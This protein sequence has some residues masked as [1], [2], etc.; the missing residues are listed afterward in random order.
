M[1]ICLLVLTSLV[2]LAG[3]AFAKTKTL[4][5]G[6]AN[7]TNL[8][9]VEV[10]YSN[11]R[12]EVTG[13]ILKKLADALTNELN[14]KPGII[15][16]PQKR[17]GPDLVSGE[18]GIVCFVHQSWFPPELTNQLLWSDEL[19]SNTNLITTIKG[20]PVSKIEDLFGKQVGAIVNYYYKK[21]D[22]YFESGKITKE[23]GPSTASNIQKLL[24][25]RMEYMIISNLEYD[26]YKKKNPELRSYDLG[27]DTVKVKCALSKKAGIELGELN[28]AIAALKKNG[29]LDKIFK[30]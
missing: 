9:F 10:D 13:G 17:V 5:Y 3:A 16:L 30:P 20:K 12:A 28:K 21:M 1:R 2:L 19:T 11:G 29:T 24:H 26:F 15:L 27:L 23:T 7:E 4:Y 14:L 6:V 25:G 8:P 22:P 18:L